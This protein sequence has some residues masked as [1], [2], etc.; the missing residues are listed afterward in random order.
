MQTFLSFEPRYHE[1]TCREGQPVWV[2]MYNP[3]RDCVQA[4][5]QRIRDEFGVVDSTAWVRPVVKKIDAREL[6]TEARGLVL[7]FLGAF[8]LGWLMS[9]VPLLND[10][11]ALAPAEHRAAGMMAM[12]CATL[13]LCSLV[14][15]LVRS[16]KSRLHRADFGD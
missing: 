12:G 16:R 9:L 14:L 1:L 11:L 3:I 2:P 8:V 13:S 10:W 7:F 5:C 6:W 4:E 15:A